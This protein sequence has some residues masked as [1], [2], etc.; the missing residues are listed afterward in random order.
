M[1]VSNIKQLKKLTAELNEL[2]TVR[3]ESHVEYAHEG[4]ERTI[5]LGLYNDNLIAVQRAFV[6]KG[7]FPR[8]AHK[9]IEVIVVYTGLCEFHFDTDDPIL[10]KRGDVLRIPPEKAHSV[11][12]I[13]DTWM[14]GITIP[15]SPGYPEGGRMKTFE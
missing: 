10:L 12:V 4:D 9:E 1:M 6:P 13:E 11:N 15:S 2:I 14:I 7:K 3:S 8:H 5:G